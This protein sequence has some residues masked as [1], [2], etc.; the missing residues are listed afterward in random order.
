MTVGEEVLL[1][2]ALATLFA[3]APLA[4]LDRRLGY[5]ISFV[6]S[7]LLVAAAIA[8]LTLGPF[9]A[10]SWTGVI[11][12]PEGLRLDALSAFFALVA[13]IV[14]AATSVYSIAYD[15]HSGPSLA[16]AYSVTIAAIALLFCATDWLLFLAAWEVMTLAAYWMILEATGRPVRIFSAAFVFLAFGE[17]STLLATVAIAALYLGTGSFAMVPLLTVG[18]LPSVVFGA[19]LVGFGLKMG[20]A[21]FHMTEW[22]PIAHSSAPSNASAVLSSTLT[23]AGVYGLFR[24]LMLMPAGPSWWGAVLLVIGAIS[25]LL[26]AIFASVSEHTKGLPAYSTIENN[27]LILVALGIALIARSDGLTTLATF[28]LFAAFFQAFAHAVTKATLFLFAGD[29]ERAVRTFDLSRTRGGV[30]EA[31]RL[32]TGAALIAA[33]SL[34]AAPPLAG[35][36]S[37]WMI[38][39]SLFQSFRFPQPALEFIGLLAG[40]VVALAAGLV[41]VAMI[42]FIGFTALW[43]PVRPPHA[44]RTRGLGVPIAGLATAVILIGVLSPWILS[45]LTPAVSGFL[46]LSVTPPVGSLLAMPNGWSILSAG[47]VHPFGVLSPPALPIAFGLGV[48]PAVAYFALGRHPNAR[49]VPAWSGGRAEPATSET[50][51]SFGYSTGMRIMFRSLLGTRETRRSSGPIAYAE[52]ATPEPYNVELEVLDVF[53]P[54]YDALIRA[55]MWSAVGMKRAIMPGRIGRY[56]AYILVVVLLVAIYISV[57]F[58][59]L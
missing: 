1:L 9:T 14:W 28:A 6:G 27:G 24:V 35:F 3:G 41:V 16:V 19:A 36:V 52:I 53:K 25:A 33:L 51:T 30:M 20:V 32:G 39:E 23:L 34:A 31:D 43:K 26:G 7:L 56:L 29:V 5:G 8:A 18:L 49:R 47:S 48:L 10:L 42:K 54:F 37:E 40:A 59:S 4:V 55:V 13:G 21:P 2:A 17:A 46:G 11:G 12:E 22:L 50:Y 57:T 38:L 45:F 58:G 15:T 44:E